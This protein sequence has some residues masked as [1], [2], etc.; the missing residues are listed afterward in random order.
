M[1]KERGKIRG[2]FFEIDGG[3]E[4]LQE[5]LRNFGTALGRALSGPPRNVRS[6]LPSPPANGKHDEPQVEDDVIDEE[7]DG[8]VV[9]S[10]PKKTGAK[11]QQ[12]MPEVVEFNIEGDGTSFKDFAAEKKPESISDKCLVAVAWFKNH[13]GLEE[14]TA[15]HVFTCFKLMG[16]THPASYNQLLSDLKRKAQTLS[17]GEGTGAYKINLAGTNVVNGMGSK[18]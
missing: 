13:G 15:N 6:A 9:P 14:V 5:G 4:T 7:V 8:E 17:K 2:F 18:G 11:K 3:D 12:P 16:W 1:A 10:K